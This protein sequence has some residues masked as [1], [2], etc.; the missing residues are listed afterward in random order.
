MSDKNIQKIKLDL[1]NYK[2]NISIDDARL[3]SILL[4]E[5]LIEIN[6][7]IENIANKMWE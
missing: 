5:I 3:P 4:V 6:T 1:E 7:H 2:K